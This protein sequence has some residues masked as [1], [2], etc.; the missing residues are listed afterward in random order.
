M[1]GEAREQFAAF[2]P[3]GDIG[4]FAGKLSG[5]ASE[6]ILQTP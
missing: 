3:D 5:D 2:I 1:S 6:V 4:Q